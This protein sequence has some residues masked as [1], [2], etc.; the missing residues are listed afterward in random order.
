[1]SLFLAEQRVVTMSIAVYGTL[2]DGLV[3]GWGVVLVSLGPSGA[4]GGGLAIGVAVVI[5]AVF[6]LRWRLLRR[7][8]EPASIAAG[9]A[10]EYF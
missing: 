3:L 2:V 4:A 8:S 7:P 5:L 6:L 1:M 10:K 9:S